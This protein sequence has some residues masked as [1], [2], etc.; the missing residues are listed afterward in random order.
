M[1][2]IE[3]LHKSL[4]SDWAKQPQNL[5]A[6][7]QLLDQIEVQLKDFAA[8]SAL[9]P[10]A[11]TSIHKDF[12][13]IS[14]LYNAA[15]AD[16]NGFQ[17]AIAKVHC[18]YESQPD[19]SSSTNKYLMFGLHLM[20]LLATNRVSDFHMLLEQI[21]ESVQQNNPYISTAVKLEE[22]LMEGAY[23]KVILTEKNIPSP[24]YAVFIRILM[25]TIRNEIASCI[26]KSYERLLVKDACNMLLFD[27]QNDM[28]SFAK[29]R[30]WKSDKNEFHFERPV[31]NAQAEVG[32]KSNLDTKRI[33]EQNLFYAK[34]LEMII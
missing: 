18:F 14:A 13:E 6:V 21:D 7:K 3:A 1:P 8:L 15:L 12:F 30:G 27:K 23:N 4:L 33:T 34:Q 16:L 11:A 25:G 19:A 31:K 20:Y 10:V 2:K 9:S 26:E 22:C 17:E 24:Y 29:Q 32:A 5:N 28:L